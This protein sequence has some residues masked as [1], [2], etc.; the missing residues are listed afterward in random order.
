[1]LTL[2]EA[3]SCLDGN[4]EGK[5]FRVNIATHDQESPEVRVIR[6]RKSEI[7]MDGDKRIILQMSD[8]T[9]TYKYNKL[10]TTQKEY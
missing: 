6:V 7:L 10:Q 9:D 1:M 8:L 5:L 2:Q 3:I 4:Q